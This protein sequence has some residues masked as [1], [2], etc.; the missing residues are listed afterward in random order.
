MSPLFPHGVS[1]EQSIHDRHSYITFSQLT[2]M[3]HLETPS[4]SNSCPCLDSFLPR[5]ILSAESPTAFPPYFCAHSVGY[6][7]GCHV[8]R[9]PY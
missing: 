8:L 4:A 6:L 9:K 3:S 7:I 5:W 2:A 1:V